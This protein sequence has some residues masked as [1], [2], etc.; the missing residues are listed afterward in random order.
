MKI[1]TIIAKLSIVKDIITRFSVIIFVI[2][3]GLVFG[4]LTFNIANYSNR[5]PSDDQIEERLSSLKTVNLNQQAVD[6]INEL[7]D[8]NINIESLFNNGRANPFEYGS[9]EWGQ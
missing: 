6:K 9:D 2:F 4:F 5:E 7:R 3:L 8:Q 1:D